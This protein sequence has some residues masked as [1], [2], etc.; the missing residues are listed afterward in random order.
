MD[1]LNSCFGMDENYQPWCVYYSFV[2]FIQGDEN[3]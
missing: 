1:L 2:L 3:E